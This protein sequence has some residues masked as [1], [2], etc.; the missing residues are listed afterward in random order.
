MSERRGHRGSPTSLGTRQVPR[1][2]AGSAYMEFKTRTSLHDINIYRLHHRRKDI[3]GP[4]SFSTDGCY[5]AVAPRPTT[6]PP[7]PPAR[8]A[9]A[10]RASTRSRN[11]SSSA[12]AP[13]SNLPHSPASHPRRLDSPRIFGSAPA[14]PATPSPPVVVVVAV[15]LP[16]V[17]LVVVSCP[18]SGP[19]PP[20]ILRISLP[21]P[22]LVPVL[23][24]PDDDDGLDLFEDACNGV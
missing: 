3:H 14:T 16:W 17:V 6:P 23:V 21:A 12:S 19:T 8:R 9:S 1:I 11:P 22:P 15:A 18:R 10:S 24:A 5:G 13:R 7:P 20:P 2:H 4:T